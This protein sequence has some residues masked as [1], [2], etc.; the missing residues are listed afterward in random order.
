MMI[1]RHI[2]F[3]MESTKSDYGSKVNSNEPLPYDTLRIDKNRKL[4]GLMGM[5]HYS[6]VPKDMKQILVIK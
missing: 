3:Q 6:K 5:K 1:D 2:A 4:L